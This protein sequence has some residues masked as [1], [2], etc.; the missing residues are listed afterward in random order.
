MFGIDGHRRTGREGKFL[1]G[2]ADV[3]W[4]TVVVARQVLNTVPNTLAYAAVKM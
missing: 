4:F 1:S 2:N 3:Q